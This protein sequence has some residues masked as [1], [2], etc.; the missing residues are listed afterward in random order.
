LFKRL[1]P[2]REVYFTIAKFENHV[3]F[4]LT[5]NAESAVAND[6]IDQLLNRG[7]IPEF[8]KLESP[9]DMYQYFTEANLKNKLLVKSKFPLLADEHIEQQNIKDDLI[10]IQFKLLSQESFRTLNTLSFINLPQRKDVNC[11]MLQ[12]IICKL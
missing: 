5:Q 1:P 9:L 8:V 10:L 4:S 3:G 12:E 6:K 11:E 7:A 2:T